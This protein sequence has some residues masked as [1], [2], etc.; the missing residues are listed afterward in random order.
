MWVPRVGTC[1]ALQGYD[2]RAR[3]TDP[4][5]TP[6]S[7]W[8][9]PCIRQCYNQPAPGSAATRTSHSDGVSGVG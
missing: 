1:R 9:K 6:P 4:G 2:A 7:R 5:R 8:V 3:G